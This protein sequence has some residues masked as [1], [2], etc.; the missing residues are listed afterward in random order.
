[1]LASVINML[2][3]DVLFSFWL[4]DKL[5]WRF[6]NL[7]Y[8]VAL[9][10]SLVVFIV[11]CLSWLSLKKQISHIESKVFITLGIFK[12]DSQSANDQQLDQQQTEPPPQPPES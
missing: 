3:V 6:N 2:I 4:F 5:N 9:S 1:M 7:W 11:S 10:V 8:W 12:P